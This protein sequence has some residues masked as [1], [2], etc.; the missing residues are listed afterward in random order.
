MYMFCQPCPDNVA[1]LAVS[2]SSSRVVRR[3]FA[4]RPDHIKDLHENGTNCLPAWRASISVGV[5]LCS[6]S[7]RGVAR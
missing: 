7:P 6:L 1:K 4:P 3:E 5:C 2:V